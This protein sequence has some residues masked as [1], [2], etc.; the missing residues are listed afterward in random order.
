MKKEITTQEA[1]YKA[2]ALCSATEYCSTE[3][4]QKLL[5]WGI[6]ENDCESIIQKLTD[7]DYINEERYCL[8]FIHDK[9]HY[10][11]WGR[12]KIHE[13]LRQKRIAGSLISETL[14]QIDP[15][16]YQQILKKILDSKNK[17]IKTDS[18]YERNGKLIRFAL[19]RGFESEYI[20]RLLPD[21]YDEE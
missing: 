3:I 2:S 15:D 14:G 4:R 10:N 11:K 12:R 1:L 19:S 18:T 6:S 17:E 5:K 7:E 9:L 8:A 13:A 20:S 21:I 16:L